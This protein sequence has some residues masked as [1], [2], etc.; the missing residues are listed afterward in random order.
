M[1]LSMAAEL[2][3]RGILAL[4]ERYGRE[5]VPLEE[6]CQQRKLPKEYLTKIFSLLGRAGL[7]RAVRGKRGGYV[8][9]RSPREV[10]LLAVVEAVE[11]PLAVNL[12]QHTP[13]RCDQD[14][15]RVRP[16]WADIQNKV[17]QA[18]AGFTLEQL[19][20]QEAQLAQAAPDQSPLAA[21]SA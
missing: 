16:I 2:A 8:L 13:S 19:I 3:V 12:C 9:A 17:R 14:D 15:C 20:S 1:K 18:L 11:G 7:I 5:P 4:A 10:T 6:I 21:Q